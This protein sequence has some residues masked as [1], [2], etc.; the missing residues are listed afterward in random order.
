M[1]SQLPAPA[2]NTGTPYTLIVLCGGQGSRLG[3]ADK[4]LLVLDGQLLAER[5]IERFG[6]ASNHADSPDVLISANRHIEQ[7]RRL[8]HPVVQDLRAGFQGPLAGIEACLHQAA[9]APVLILPADMPDL[10]ADL[11]QILLGKLTRQSIV[12]AHDGEQSQ[13]LCMA[14]HP[15]YWQESLTAWLDTGARS[16]HGWLSDKP[17]TY[18]RFKDTFGFSN[19]NEK[20]DLFRQNGQMIQ[21]G[22]QITRIGYDRRYEQPCCQ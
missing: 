19:I 9:T 20:K 16:V 1:S 17:V 7:Y 5:I 14:M 10:P 8:G 18:A 15:Y 13:P 11:P 12:I 22:A 2:A 3:G 6:S 21:I 4:G